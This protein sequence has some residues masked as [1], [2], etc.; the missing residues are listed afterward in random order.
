M[1]D[2][3]DVLS[4]H[5]D[6]ISDHVLEEVADDVSADHSDSSGSEKDDDTIMMMISVTQK[7]MTI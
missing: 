4:V 1:N 2:Q 6:S 5:S 3:D 7:C